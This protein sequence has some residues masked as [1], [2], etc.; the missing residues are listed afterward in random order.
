MVPITSYARLCDFL[1][2]DFDYWR[3]RDRDQKIRL[4]A[5]LFARPHTELASRE[6]FPE[7]EYFDQ[8]LGPRLHVFV[9]GCTRGR[10]GEFPDERPVG[11]TDQW[12][13]S[14]VA[15]NQLR[16]DLE[17]R[18]RWRYREACELL[19]LNTTFDRKRAA[20]TVDCGSAVRIDL[21]KLRALGGIHSVAELIGR[22]ADYCD[23][24]ENKNDPAWGFSDSMGGKVVG[25]SLWH[26][27]IS[28]I[29]EAV[30]KDAEAA[31]EFVT[32]D[33]RTM[34]FGNSL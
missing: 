21:D 2:Q 5:I 23:R 6:I 4:C 8:R 15:F 33:L 16:V 25:A 12:R 13:Y 11:R 10:V 29:P 22:M 24:S 18:T 27:L 20:A 7:L 1:T 26:L 30:R 31:R 19:V 32:A 14:D 34:P 3:H 28:F 9:A 17:S